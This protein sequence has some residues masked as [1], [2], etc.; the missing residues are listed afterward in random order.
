VEAVL[1]DGSVLHGLSRVVKDNMGYD[2]RHLLIGSEGTLGLITAASLRLFPAPGETATAWVSVASPEAALALAQALRQSLGG[3]ISAFELIHVRGLEF[4]AEVLP[5][6]P[7]PPPMPADWRVLVET[8]DAAG[9]ATE[10]RLEAAL[11]EALE[12]GLVADVL[13]AQNAAQR[14]VFWGVREAIPEAN[15][16]IGSVSSH[17]ISLPPSRLGAFVALAAPAIATLDPDLRINCFGHLG[18]GNLHYNVFPP[19]GRDRALYDS[20]REPVM[21]TVHDLVHGLGGSVAAE[22]GVGRLKV[23]DLVRYG[24]PSKVGAMRAIKRA[25]DPLGILNPGAVLT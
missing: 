20:L 12:A 17:D 10:A 19:R 22:H 4:L 16:L 6:I 1:A 21:R 9:A 3:T 24:D 15:R 8:A 2:L 13:I 14:A 25:L 18:D 11:A 5:R 23:G 7:V